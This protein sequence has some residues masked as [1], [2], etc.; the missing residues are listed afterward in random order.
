MSQT[1]LYHYLESTKVDL[2][3]YFESIGSTND[4]ALEWADQGA[5][6]YSLV[7]AD[8][9]TNG[10]GRFNRRWI[11]RP[12]TSL[13]FSLILKPTAEELEKIAL[14]SPL[15]GLAV[16]DA[17][18]I[19]LNLK[20]EIKWPNDVLLNRRKFCGI[21]VEAAWTAGQINGIVLGI[22]IN[23]SAGSIPPGN[24]LLFPAACLE[25]EA[26]HKVDRFEI[27]KD[28]ILAIQK[29]RPFLG[30]EIFFRTW[31]DNLAFKGE[32]VQV[33]GTG[34]PAIMGILKGVD[35]QGKLVLVND[36]KIEMSFEIGDVHLRPGAHSLP[37][38]NDAG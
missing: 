10:R 35:S 28:V 29:W 27:L 4:I 22:G 20:P 7:V 12:G 6:D 21:L 31:Q 25:Q 23:I 11:T 8:D 16:H 5:P 26:G 18:Q 33:E 36:N 24:D 30:E 37:G 32:L 17:V 1:N 9:Q 13:A 2:F 14:F 19:G 38:A 34:K 3:K 15:C